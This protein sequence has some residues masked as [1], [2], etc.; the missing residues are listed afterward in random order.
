MWYALALSAALLVDAGPAWM[1]GADIFDTFA[2]KKVA[3]N[4]ASGLDFTEVY[5]KDGTTDYR[6]PQLKI[7]GRWS[8]V[9]GMFCTLYVEV[10]GGCFRVARESANCYAIYVAAQ[11]EDEARAPTILP[12][13]IARCWIA[14]TPSTCAPSIVS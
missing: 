11:T 6:D 12:R 14:D 8:V 5:I 3:G 2:G 7:I 13:W 1:Q 4:Y 9:N 10:Q